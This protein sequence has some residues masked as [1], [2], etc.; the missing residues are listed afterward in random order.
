[1]GEGAEREIRAPERRPTERVSA[2]FF[3]PRMRTW[4]AARR[5]LQRIV[6][7]VC[8]GVPHESSLAAQR[9]T[10][11][12][13]EQARWLAPE[14]FRLRGV[15]LAIGGEVLVWSSNEIMLLDRGLDSMMAMA[16]PEKLSASAAGLRADGLIEVL[17]TD[18]I[19]VHLLDWEGHLLSA[20]TFASAHHLVHG[21]W[22]GSDWVVLVEGSS[23]G[24]QERRLLRLESGGDVR[25][26]E[27][28]SVDAVGM[29][30][31]RDNRVLFAETSR[32]FR[33]RMLEGDRFLQEIAPPTPLLDSLGIKPGEGRSG[34]WIS[35][36]AL[37]LGSG[38][39]QTLAD[40]SS[41]RRLILVFDEVGS[42]AG[43]RLVEA[44]LGF[45]ASD[46]GEQTLIAVRQLNRVEV[47]RYGWRWR[48]P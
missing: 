26:T 18:P 37:P 4:P 27:L 3:V 2:S 32:P 21:V 25:V 20:D 6:L 10:I 44:P 38:V 42:L 28:A 47:V 39:L 22:S 23:A 8:L 15:S 5:V 43:H 36:P 17:S 31:A 46:G 12:L 9:P 14:A 13:V 41:D 35:L 45:V 1:M 16:L 40:L 11:D 29:L 34:N 33:I 7:W 30:A 24:A 48:A 19:A